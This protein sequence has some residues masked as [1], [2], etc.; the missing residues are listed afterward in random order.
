MK[1]FYDIFM[2][3]TNHKGSINPCVFAEALNNTAAQRQMI[4]LVSQVDQIIDTISGNQAMMEMW[5]RY[6]AT[7]SYASGISF[8]K[9]ISTLH[10]LAKWITT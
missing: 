7:Y 2:L 3:V 10:I 4:R 1:D 9:I 6:S 5:K 8:E